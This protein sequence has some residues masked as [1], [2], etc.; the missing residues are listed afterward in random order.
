EAAVFF[1][2]GK[3]EEPKRSHFRERISGNGVVF[4]DFRFQWN[5]PLVD[6]AANAGKQRLEFGGLHQHTWRWVIELSRCGAHCTAREPVSRKTTLPMV[7]FARRVAASAS[8][9]SRRQSWVTAVVSFKFICQM[10]R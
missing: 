8:R 1:R 7:W 5:E 4:R 2:N 6:E 9:G 10:P 3:T